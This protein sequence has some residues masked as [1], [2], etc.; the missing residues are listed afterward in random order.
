MNKEFFDKN[1]KRLLELMED[2]SIA[3]FF[4]GHAPRRQGDE[5]F[6]FEPNRNFYYF[7]GIDEENDIL[8]LSKNNNK[9][10]LFINEFDEK[11][12]KWVGRGYNKAE[13]VSLSNIKNIDYIQNFNFFL[14]DLIKEENVSK[15][16]LDLELDE[17]KDMPSY[18]FKK[19]NKEVY[20]FVEFIDVFPLTVKLRSVK[21][22]EEIELIRKAISITNKGLNAVLKNIRNFKS[23]KEAQALFE[24]T[25]TLNGAENVAFWTIAG[26]GKNGTT[27]HYSS[28]N[29]E[30]NPKDLILLDLGAQ[31]KLYKSDITRTYPLSG[32][33][34]DRQK[35]IYDIVLRG[36][37]AVLDIIKPGIP[38]TLMQ[39]TLLKFYSVELKKIGLI[40]DD[41]EIINYYW[42]GVGHHLGLDTHDAS[43][44]VR[45]SFLEE[46]N[47][48]T[49]EPGLYIAEEGIGIRIEDDIL[50][51]K[52]G[53]EVLSK[54]IVK[55]LDEI[56][57]IINE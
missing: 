37:K 42:H 21:Q 40:K 27:L 33:Y 26:S 54:E 17:Y 28:N 18:K 29:C 55:D 1:R 52:D 57:R 6:K 12:A 20:P 31:Y 11:N 23:E 3:I 53:C 48:V 13:V 9:S 5:N 24:Y 41:S 14:K 46:G 25:I 34:S 56:E 44:H 4:A 8:L 50:V 32:K 16:Y 45:D 43:Y 38:Y 30:T 22:E 2:N 39:E 36:Q 19:H 7:T 35:Q 15:I 47:I 51:T 10:Y 49:C